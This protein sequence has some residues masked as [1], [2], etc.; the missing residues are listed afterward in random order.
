MTS[1]AI[2]YGILSE[3]QN[4]EKVKIIDPSLATFILFNN[5]WDD[6]IDIKN[7]LIGPYI[8]TAIND[9]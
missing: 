5:D 9:A 1:E 2:Y 8:I 3:T 6:L 7:E 4:N